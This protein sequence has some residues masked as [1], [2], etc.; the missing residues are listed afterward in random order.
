MLR[1]R[2]EF[3]DEYLTHKSI[4]CLHINFPDPWSKKAKRKH[5]IL[6]KE[7]LIKIHPYF[8]SGGELRFKTDHLEYFKTVTHTLN[9]LDFYSIEQHTEDLHKSAYE[10][11][12]ILTEFEMLFKSKRN[13]PIRYLR[14]KAI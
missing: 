6:S 4:D 1:E 7:F 14:A 5:R 2:G 3:L 8:C 12:N 13:P 10:K 11:D 9:Q